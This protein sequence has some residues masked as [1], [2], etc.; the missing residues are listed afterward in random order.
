MQMKNSLLAPL[1]LGGVV[2]V[3]V[4]AYAGAQRT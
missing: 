4:A 3:A 2:V 1:I